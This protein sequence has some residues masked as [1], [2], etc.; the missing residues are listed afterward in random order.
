MSLSD[1]IKN[2]ER[3]A[4]DLPY[5]A[6]Q[7]IVN[8][9]GNRFSFENHGFMREI[10]ES[11]EDELVIKKS[12][13]VGAT[14][15]ALVKLLWVATYSNITAIYTMPKGGDI[16][17]F[18]QARRD[19]IIIKSGLR[20]KRSPGHIDNMGLIRLGGSFLYFKGTWGETEAISVPSD[21]NIHDEVDFSKPQVIE[22]YEERLSGQGSLRWLLYMSTPTYPDFGISALYNETDQ[23]EW[24]VTCPNGHEQI[25]SLANIQD[26]K[27]LCIFCQAELDRA[28]GKWVA[29]KPNKKKV[30][31][32][33]TQLIASWISAEAI[34]AK[35]KKYK[36]V[37]DFY[38][39]VL[40]EGYLGGEI[41]V[42]GSDINAC[43]GDMTVTTGRTLIGV[44]WGN[45]TWVVARRD[46]NIIGM[47]KITGD[48]RTHAKQVIKIAKKYDNVYGVLDFGYGDTKN[49]EVIESFNT[50]N[51]QRFYM[52]KFQKGYIYPKFHINKEES[53]GA[54]MPFVNIDRTSAVEE[55]LTE[56]KGGDAVICNNNLMP[57]FIQHF[58][59]IIEIRE[60]D[61]SGRPVITYGNKGDDHFVFADLYSRIFL[62]VKDEDVFVGTEDEDWD[63]S[64]E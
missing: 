33:P 40:G 3:G 9:K 36:F 39:F 45:I 47:F 19:P 54:D 53:T 52:C 64:P 38:N 58:E 61:K 18:S 56:I 44:D 20:K 22:M 5:W 21:Y 27:F 17:D 34:M 2:I 51:T 55:T 10:Y 50:R 15:F 60:E 11:W 6:E 31:Y 43:I 42:T 12:A 8:E 63:T 4:C 23:R 30:G 1:N 35:K 49:K 46:N 29:Q 24:V 57:E 37:K 62:Q 7:N 16:S 32:H 59:N 48:T 41:M 14:F 25:M 13:Q 26:N 28:N